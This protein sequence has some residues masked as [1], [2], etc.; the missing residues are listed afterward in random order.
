MQ[1]KAHGIPNTLRMRDDTGKTQ[2]I[3]ERPISVIPSATISIWTAL[4]EN[5]GVL[6]Q[7]RR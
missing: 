6:R 1:V 5:I 2:A 3:E 7:N 4:G